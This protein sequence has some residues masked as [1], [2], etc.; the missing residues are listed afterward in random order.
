MAER[1]SLQVEAP[2]PRLEFMAAAQDTYRRPT[3][4]VRSEIMA[5]RARSLKRM[6]AAG[7]LS[8]VSGRRRSRRR[9]YRF[10]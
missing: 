2:R 3:V 7:R 6:M 5:P 8:P 9:N 4:R 10:P 1:R